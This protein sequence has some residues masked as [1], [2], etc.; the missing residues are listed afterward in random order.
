MSNRDVF[1]WAFLIRLKTSALNFLHVWGYMSVCGHFIMS[2]NISE[3]LYY[4]VSQYK[5]PGLEMFCYFFFHFKTV[6]IFLNLMMTIKIIYLSCIYKKECNIDLLFIVTKYIVPLRV[7][8]WITCIVKKYTMI[9]IKFNSDSVLNGITQH[10]ID[11]NYQI[12]NV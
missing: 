1:V 9:Y 12:Y 5:W 7:L 11:I 2:K 6:T 4:Y 10:I 3:V 8:F